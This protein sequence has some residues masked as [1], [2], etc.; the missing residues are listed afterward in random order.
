MTCEHLDIDD[1]L[2]TLTAP[3]RNHYYYGKMMDVL[4]FQMEQR[5]VNQK[6]WLINRLSLG[7]GIL[8]GLGVE[9]E[10]DQL[11]V[12]CGVGIDCYGREVIVPQRFCVDPWKLLDPCGNPSGELSR[13]ERHVVTLSVCYHECLT[14]YAPILVSTCETKDECH[15]GTVIESYRPQIDVGP[16]SRPRPAFDPACC[17][18]LLG[19]TP[20]TPSD[21]ATFTVVDTLAV[22]GQP[23]G[24]AATADGQWVVI[25]HTNTAAA[26][27]HVVAVASHAVSAIQ[28]DVITKPSGHVAVAPSGGPAFVTHTAGLAVVDPTVSTTSIVKNIRETRSYGAVAAVKAGKTVFAVNV[29]KKVIEVIDVASASEIGTIPV[30]GLPRDLAVSPDETYLYIT[31]GD[32]S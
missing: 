28:A 4:H 22:G 6:R 17:E 9:A 5:Y 16:A 20:T 31:T 3:R 25:A 19:G 23:M 14:D 13:A 18:E 10:G 29:P 26:A 8:C 27:V 12:D 30:P 15:P 32:Q 7:D 21:T 11:C 24:V 2:R 1:M